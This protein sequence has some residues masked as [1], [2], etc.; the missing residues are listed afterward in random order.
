VTRDRERQLVA[1]DPGAVV[2]DANPLSAAPRE[3]DV[4]LRRAGIE[5]VLEQLLQRR[6]GALDDLARRSG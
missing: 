2:G 1:L 6:C 4:D 5:R 3:I